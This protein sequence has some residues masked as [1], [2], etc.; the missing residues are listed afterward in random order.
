LKEHPDTLIITMDV[1]EEVNPTNIDVRG[2]NAYQRDRKLMEPF[3]KMAANHP[4][5]AFLIV[6]HARKAEGDNVLHKVSGSQELAGSVDN[7]LIMQSVKGQKKHAL[8][9]IKSRDLFTDD[10]YPD[11]FIMQHGDVG[12]LEWKYVGEPDEN[13]FDAPQRTKETQETQQAKVN[14][15]CK[16]VFDDKLWVMAKD[17]TALAASKGFFSATEL[18][19][20][21]S[22]NGIKTSKCKKYY[23]VDGSEPSAHDIERCECEMVEIENMSFFEDK[24]TREPK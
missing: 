23:F 3:R 24:S 10:K 1:L 2:L 6:H 12:R 9:D 7:L 4:T 20:A 11:S 17:Y 21:R 8:V 14:I 16:K 15:W 18:S 5:V 19:R 22:K 13:E